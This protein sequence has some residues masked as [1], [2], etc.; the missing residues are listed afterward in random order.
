MN[1]FKLAVVFVRTW[2]AVW[3]GV[4]AIGLAWSGVASV[5]WLEAI[6]PAAL[7]DVAGSLWYLLAGSALFL[8]SRPLARLLSKGLD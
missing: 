7:F 2:A 5:R 1:Y 8:L 6:V 3:L 4:A